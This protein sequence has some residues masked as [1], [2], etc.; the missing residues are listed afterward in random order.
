MFYRHVQVYKVLEGGKLKSIFCEA[1]YAL[2]DHDNKKP[3]EQEV[4][5]RPCYGKDCPA[6]IEITARDRIP[7]K[8]LF[9]NAAKE[10]FEERRQR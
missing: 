8:T 10:R 1:L 5:F 2:D 7:K 4:F 3:F 9:W 6:S